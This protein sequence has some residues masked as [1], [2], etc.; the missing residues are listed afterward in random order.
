M[1][2]VTFNGVTPIHDMCAGFKEA[3]PVAIQFLLEH[4]RKLASKARGW[5][6]NHLLA[7]IFS[8]KHK[9]E[10]FKLI[11]KQTSMKSII[12]QIDLKNGW[13]HYQKFSFEIHIG[14][15]VAK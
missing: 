15:S 8:A 10:T 5:F 12:R 6:S 1:R 14:I 2:P 13:M 11:L 9:L 4:P 7:D 3:K